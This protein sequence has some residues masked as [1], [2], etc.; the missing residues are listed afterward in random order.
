MFVGT[1]YAF[2]K[3]Y[4]KKANIGSKWVKYRTSGFLRNILICSFLDIDLTEQAKLS[5]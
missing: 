4:W 5:P 3:N 2:N 1:G